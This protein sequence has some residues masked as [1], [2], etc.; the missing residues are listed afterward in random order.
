MN[1]EIY[2]RSMVAKVTVAEIQL[3][4]SE[5]CPFFESRNRLE[6]TGSDGRVRKM[7][8][9]VGNSQFSMDVLT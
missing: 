5:A 9:A 8:I 7:I 6:S 1:D 3:Q 4:S 2:L